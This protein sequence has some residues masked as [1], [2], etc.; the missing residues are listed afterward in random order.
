MTIAI[1]TTVKIEGQEPLEALVDDLRELE[2]FDGRTLS[3]SLHSQG[4]PAPLF[5]PNV[6]A[7]PIH[8]IVLEVLARSDA[9]R[10]SWYRAPPRGQ[11]F[12]E[13]VRAGTASLRSQQRELALALM[14]EGAPHS[15]TS[16]TALHSH[17]AAEIKQRFGG[18]ISS[19][20]LK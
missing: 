19:K 5:L 3:F 20:L 17:Y 15:L 16:R 6:R 1:K 7:R 12:P 9:V 11:P 2:R 4:A 13:R 8:D 14:R 10:S 18:P